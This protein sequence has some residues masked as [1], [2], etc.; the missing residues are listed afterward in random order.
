MINSSEG[1]GSVVLLPEPIIVRVPLPEAYAF[2]EFKWFG[3]ADTALQEYMRVLEASKAPKS[4]NKGLSTVNWNPILVDYL[5]GKSLHPDN[6]HA[7]NEK[8]QWMI[9]EIKKAFSR[10]ELKVDINYEDGPG[11]GENGDYS[12]MS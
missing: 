11:K 9:Q 2:I 8:Q 1:G 3:T 4:E 7:M 6:Y 12:G 5:N 10:M